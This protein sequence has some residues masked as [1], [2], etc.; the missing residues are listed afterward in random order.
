MA[1]G[2]A[3]CL[4]LGGGTGDSWGAPRIF[5][6]RAKDKAQYP[7]TP[8]ILILLGFRPLDFGI[9]KSSRIKK[10]KKMANCCSGFPRHLPFISL[11]GDDIARYL[12]VATHNITNIFFLSG[13]TVCRWECDSYYS[14]I[15]DL[16]P[17]FLSDPSQILFNSHL[18]TS[19]FY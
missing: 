19:F 11:V 16:A 7:P 15:R 12:I 2:S 3:T 10:E 6:R 5:L 9:S 13:R 14:L 4:G 1:R 17:L 18:G 8:K